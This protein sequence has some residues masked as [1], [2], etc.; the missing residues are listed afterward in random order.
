VD[1]HDCSAVSVSLAHDAT[2]A[3]PDE[4]PVRNRTLAPTRRSS[5]TL[6]G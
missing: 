4:H 2:I 3:V 1:R 6:T 5:V